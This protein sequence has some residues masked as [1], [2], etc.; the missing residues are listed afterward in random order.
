AARL[1]SSVTSPSTFKWAAHIGTAVAANSTRNMD[2][3]LRIGSVLQVFSRAG[4][5][6]SPADR[7]DQE[8][9]AFRSLYLPTRKSSFR[10]SLFLSFLLLIGS[11]ALGQSDRRLDATQLLQQGD[12]ALRLGNSEEALELYTNAIQ[13]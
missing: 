9:D 12:I 10:R 1:F 13:M 4:G 6:T 7:G 3:R 2:R 5:E 8:A 11:V